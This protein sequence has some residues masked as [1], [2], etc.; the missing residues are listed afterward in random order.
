MEAL[1]HEALQVLG[2]GVA[3]LLGVVK[4]VHADV[5]RHALQS[6]Q[7]A[8][9]LVR[10]RAAEALHFEQYFV[11]RGT[12]PT[13]AVM[14]DPAEEPLMTLGSMTCVQSAFTTPMW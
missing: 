1:G 13:M 3:Q 4:E 14:M 7:V 10:A 6:H 8:Q 5:V 9:L 12:C 2:A 11:R